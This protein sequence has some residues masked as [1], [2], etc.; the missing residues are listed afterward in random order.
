MGSSIS[1]PSSPLPVCPPPSQPIHVSSF[2]V[3]GEGGIPQSVGVGG[4]CSHGWVGVSGGG[5]C[6]HGLVGAGGGGGCSPGLVGVHGEWLF[7]AGGVEEGG[8]PQCQ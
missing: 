1:S 3:R 5:G 2:P 8:T 6:S 4:G 7:G